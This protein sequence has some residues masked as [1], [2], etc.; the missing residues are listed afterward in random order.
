M[1]NEENVVPVIWTT[2]GEVLSKTNDDMRGR[3]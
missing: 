2:P 3:H 1:K